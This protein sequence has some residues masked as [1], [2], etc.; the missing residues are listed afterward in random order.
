MYELFRIFFIAVARDVGMVSPLAELVIIDIPRQNNTRQIRSAPNP[1][2]VD[3]QGRFGDRGWG[4][5][6]L[7]SEAPEEEG[8]H[9]L[10]AQLSMAKTFLGHNLSW[11]LSKKEEEELPG[12]K[13][14]SECAPADGA[15]Q[16]R[17]AGQNT[18]ALA[19]VAPSAPPSAEAA[20]K[21]APQR[22]EL[23]H[24]HS[25][26]KARR[27]VSTE[28]SQKRVVLP[29]L[30]AASITNSPVPSGC[31]DAS[32]NALLS[33]AMSQDN[34]GRTPGLT[35]AAQGGRISPDARSPF[36]QGGS[37]TPPHGHHSN[38][39]QTFD[40]HL[41]AQQTIAPALRPISHDHRPPPILIPITHPH[42]SPTSVASTSPHQH[43]TSNAPAM[44][45]TSSSSGPCLP[46]SPGHQ[47]EEGAL[48][49]A[50]PSQHPDLIQQS[51]PHE[52]GPFSGKTASWQRFTR[53]SSLGVNPFLG[54]FTTAGFESQPPGGRGL[55][56]SQTPP[57]A[58]KS[59]LAGLRFFQVQGKQ[60]FEGS[61][62]L[63]ALA[64][65]Q[66]QCAVTGDALEHMLQLKDT[67]LLEAVIRNTVVFARM[68]PHQK[69]QVMDLLGTAGLHQLFH[70][71]H[72]HIEVHSAGML[73]LYSLTCVLCAM[74][75][76][77]ML[78]CAVM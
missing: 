24:R 7:V 14:D 58:P 15:S 75:V 69:G 33:S 25:I 43:H 8:G 20:R 63:S 78:R 45:G 9:S 34:L 66:L 72:R 46:P 35:S 39:Q 41:E 22:G 37:P 71:Q 10:E 32:S 28:R 53:H 47:E 30:P 44:H 54:L 67:S 77:C 4:Q 65:G 70:G 38:T 18:M 73:C 6:G 56:P 57:A 62:A 60:D 19:Q 12:Q 40:V 61:W 23:S 59:G 26:L 3:S 21:A 49:A 50:D 17:P 68:K 51:M 74:S 36:F 52:A 55:N 76:L 2:G 11:G 5:A 48:A 42:Q 1:Q 29:P 64:E 31:S 13:L 27:V 16:K